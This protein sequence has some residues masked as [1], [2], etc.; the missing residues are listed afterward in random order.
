ML[1]TTQV[2]TEIQ[3]DGTQVLRFRQNRFYDPN[4]IEG[5]TGQK[6]AEVIGGRYDAVLIA[7]NRI[8]ELNRGDAPKI[9]RRYGNRVTAIQEM[10]QGL[11]GYEL[12][13]K[14]YKIANRHERRDK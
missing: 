8:R 12:F 14:T 4:S 9:E 13:G 5:R 7:A 1:D 2:Y 3:A 10:E 11:V 6:T